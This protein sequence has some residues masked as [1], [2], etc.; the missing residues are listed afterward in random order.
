MCDR[1]MLPQLDLCEIKPETCCIIFRTSERRWTARKL[2]KRV[3][4]RWLGR[5]GNRVFDRLKVFLVLGTSC[6][7]RIAS[8]C[9]PAK[10]KMGF[11]TPF[12]GEKR[13]LIWWTSNGV[14]AF[15]SV[16]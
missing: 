6:R 16:F 15:P 2:R 10:L 8:K 4:P 1:C 5:V 13:F 7:G 12:D 3:L 9:L 14:Q 11:E